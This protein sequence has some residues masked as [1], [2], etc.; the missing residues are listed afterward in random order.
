[1][2]STPQD[3][4]GFLETWWVELVCAVIL[5]VAVPLAA[6]YTILVK[7]KL[8]PGLLNRSAATEPRPRDFFQPVAR[9]FATL[10][11]REPTPAGTDTLIF[12][13]API[14]AMVAALTSIGALYVGPSFRVA[15]DINIGILFILGV[16]S[17]GFLGILLNGEASYTRPH[18]SGAIR[19]AAQFVSYGLAA[20]LAIVSALFLCGTLKIHAIVD[21]QSDQRVWFIFL[22]P[23][24]FLIYLLASIFGINRRP[25]QDPESQSAPAV[26]ATTEYGGFRWSLYFLGE[27]ANMIVV[28]SVA[29]T[30]FLGGW[31]RP[32]P[33]VRWLY[34]LDDL[35]ALLMA[36]I[37]AYCIY[38]AGKQ[39]T[40][41]HTWFARIAALGCLVLALL[42][43]LPWIFSPLRFAAPGLNS[44]FWFLLK[45]SIDLSFVFWLRS[46]LP[47][48][49]FDQLVHLGWYILIPLAMTNLF[50]V[51]I[52]LLFASEFG[53][54]R[55]LALILANVL[56]AAALIFLV[57]LNDK[58]PAS[59]H[60]T[61]TL[62]SDSHAG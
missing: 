35:P 6:G 21:A 34:W 51:A 10:M 17:L 11:R 40:K 25:F 27:Y 16:S 32:F 29:T 57:H 36:S 50:F 52:A 55:W 54:N 58:R 41:V 49:R 13:L 19:A 59:V 37:G 5:V 33:N 2:N 15:R 61:P 4:L 23:F 46:T 18:V 47:Q 62:T 26:G 42:L 43:F 28:A 22:A 44:A 48:W 20:S 56:T 45:V 38:R 14:V 30:V 53:W 60:R 12:W 39:P 1:M 9:A 24:G 8:L 7:R 31:L 3:I